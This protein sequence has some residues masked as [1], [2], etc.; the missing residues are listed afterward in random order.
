MDY[1]NRFKSTRWKDLNRRTVNGYGRK[2]KQSSHLRKGIRVEITKEEFYAWCE[3]QRVLIESLNAKGLRPSLDRINSN[4]NYELNNIR[5]IPH[6]DNVN[7]GRRARWNVQQQR[8]QSYRGSDL[9]LAL[10]RERSIRGYTQRSF[11][12]LVGIAYS[13]ITMYETGKA[14]PTLTNMLR[15]AR[16]LNLS[17][18][19]FFAPLRVERGQGINK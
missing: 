3:S 19:E 11:G 1:V 17:L 18:D 12:T 8:Y 7:E 5:I 4:G 9:G 15:M 13:H 6:R 16:A 14:I 10:K 2:L